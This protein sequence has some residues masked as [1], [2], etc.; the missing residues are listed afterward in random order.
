[1]FFAPCHRKCHLGRI[2]QGELLTCA[3]DHMCFKI[4]HVSGQFDSYTAESIAKL[5]IAG[6]AS[7]AGLHNFFFPILN[8]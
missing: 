5:N 6:I 7:R 8:M 2:E 4:M 1:M 3:S